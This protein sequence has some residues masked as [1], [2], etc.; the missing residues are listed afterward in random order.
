[1][2]YYLINSSGDLD[3]IE[4]SPQTKV[5]I[6][7]NIILVNSYKYVRPHKLPDF[8]PNLEIKLHK[9]YGKHF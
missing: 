9:K 4:H 3:V 2:R 7:E 8:E 6:R 5:V 1:M